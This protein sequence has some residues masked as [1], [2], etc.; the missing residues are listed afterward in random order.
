M[1]TENINTP[2]ATASGTAPALGPA[3]G[4]VLDKLYSA[5]GQT[6]GEPD[7]RWTVDDSA[8][9][10]EIDTGFKM[11]RLTR[12][13]ALALLECLNAALPHMAVKL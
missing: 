12:A 13:E 4:S 11:L 7:M 5:H 6:V 9:V 3:T 10:L 2:S 1:D 8:R